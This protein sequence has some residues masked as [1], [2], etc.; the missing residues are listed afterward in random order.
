MTDRD[1]YAD[2]FRYRLGQRVRWAEHP[3]KPHEILQRRWTQR[4]ILA[5]VVQ[6]HL[7]Y[8]ES[9][10]AIAWVREEDIEPWTDTPPRR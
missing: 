6:Y 10:M 1:D 7:G 5:P 9:G 4:Q 8:G 3:A 2:M